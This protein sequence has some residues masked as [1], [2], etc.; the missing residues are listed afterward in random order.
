[1]QDPQSLHQGHRHSIRPVDLLDLRRD[2]RIHAAEHVRCYLDV[3]RTHA[4][5]QELFLDDVV[6]PSG[7][8]LLQHFVHGL[9]VSVIAVLL[10]LVERIFPERILID[11]RVKDRELRPHVRLEIVDQIPVSVIHLVLVIL[12]GGLEVRVRQFIGFGIKAPFRLENS[13]FV[14]TAVR[15]RVL[16]A[17]GD[18]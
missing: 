11:L 1:M 14:D 4:N 17:F 6:L 15:D 2:L 3:L 10:I 7:N 16:G 13:V 5:G 9:P 18:L 12:R 8:L